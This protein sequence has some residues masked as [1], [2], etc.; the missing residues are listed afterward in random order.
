MDT[1]R[2]GFCE[3]RNGSTTPASARHATASGSLGLAAGGRRPLEVEQ[4]QMIPHESPS[5]LRCCCET[6]RAKRL[7]VVTHSAH[8]LQPRKNSR[9]PDW[10]WRCRARSA[11]TSVCHELFRSSRSV[12]SRNWP[13]AASMSWPF[14]RRNVAGT[15]QRS[16]AARNA[17]CAASG[18]RFHR[19]PST[20]L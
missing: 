19:S 20:L 14:S 4:A 10:Q 11:H 8:A 12:F 15:C 5:L 7:L 16:S 17:S 3:G 13:H 18:G 1:E 6:E 2:H 9:R